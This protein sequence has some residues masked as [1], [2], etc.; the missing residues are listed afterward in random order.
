MM[1]GGISPLDYLC[2]VARPDVA[3]AYIDLFWPRF[4]VFNEYVFREGFDEDNVRSWEGVEKVKRR[5]IKAAV[6]YLVVGFFF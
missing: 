3:V 6:N 2:S 1:A 5:N 4:V